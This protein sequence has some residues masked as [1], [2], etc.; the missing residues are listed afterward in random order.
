MLFI[1]TKPKKRRQSWWCFVF[2]ALAFSA[3]I[4]DNQIDPKQSQ[5]G[6]SGKIT[7]GYVSGR[8]NF[9]HGQLVQVAGVP[10][11]H[12]SSLVIAPRNSGDTLLL[13]TSRYPVKA[14]PDGRM[15]YESVSALSVLDAMARYLTEKLN[16]A[17]FSV[18][19]TQLFTVGKIVVSNRNN[20]PISLVAPAN[21]P[22]SISDK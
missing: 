16:P 11:L 6:S 19:K 14:M 21:Y 22:L 5:A 8:D 17:K 12:D 15:I 1:S 7:I 4:N 20:E 3:C 13:P 18:D 10:M 2:C 9:R